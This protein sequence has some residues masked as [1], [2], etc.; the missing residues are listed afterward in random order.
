VGAE[1]GGV[2]AECGPGLH[3]RLRSGRPI[4]CGKATTCRRRPTRAHLLLETV[5]LATVSWS[6]R[7]PA[8]CARTW[9]SSGCWPPNR[10]IITRQSPRT[11][12]EARPIRDGYARHNG[13][14]PLPVWSSNR[15]RNRLSRTG[16]RQLNAALHRIALTQAHWHTDARA[17]SPVAKPTATAAAK[18]Y[19]S[20]SDASPMSST[21]P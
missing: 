13:T 3:R 20:S 21:E 16:N 11:Q 2:V 15:A 5:N 10:S 14:A 17:S 9:S 1:I 6:T 8:R 7:T 4:G 12:T 19:A 18:P